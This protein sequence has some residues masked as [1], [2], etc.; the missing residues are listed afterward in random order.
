MKSESIGNLAKALSAAQGDMGPAAMTA[1]NPFLKNKYADLGEIIKASKT[2]L[3]KHGLAVSQPVTNTDSG[4]AVTTILMHESG[5]W[6]ESTVELPL[7]EERGKSMAQAA[8]SV[9]TYLRRYSLAAMIGVYA[10]EDTD[11]N[12]A[13]PANGKAQHPPIE[14][15]VVERPAPAPAA[16]DDKTVSD[17]QRQIV[18]HMVQHTNLARPHVINT[19]KKCSLTADA[20]LATWEAWWGEYRDGRTVGMSSDDAAAAA[21]QKMSETVAQ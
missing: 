11:G 7:T 9:I 15:P 19:L 4:I 2:A 12:E 14:P 17:R 1:T 13:K 6:L 3:A 21:N 10:D 16:T 5:E 20:P 8:G 18:D